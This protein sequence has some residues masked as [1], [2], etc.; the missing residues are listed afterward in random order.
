M[1]WENA[2]SPL[3]FDILVFLTTPTAHSSDICP[4]NRPFYVRYNIFDYYF[5]LKS[6]FRCL[7]IAHKTEACHH[8]HNVCKICQDN[9]LA[10]LAIGHTRFKII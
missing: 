7:G 3:N 8:L 1:Q 5:V 4:R 6:I 10:D 2:V 9:G